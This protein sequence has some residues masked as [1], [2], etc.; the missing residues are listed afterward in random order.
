MKKRVRQRK[1]GREAGPRKALVVSLA[2]ALIEKERIR[3]TEAKAKAI[4][5]F[6]EKCVTKGKKADLAARR[7][8]ISFFEPEI[9]KKVVEDIA[10][11]YKT[12][13]G[14]YTR[15]VK[16]APRGSDGARMAI[17]EFVK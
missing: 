10:P 7:N 16:V 3:T 2:R 4:S 6:V 9:A 13:K 17:I 14:G 8:L 1:F 5:P 11:R 15:V 12:R